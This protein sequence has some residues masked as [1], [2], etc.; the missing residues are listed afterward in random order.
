MGEDEGDTGRQMTER[1]EH[2]EVEREF[3]QSGEDTPA[4]D[5]PKD[6]ESSS[7]PSE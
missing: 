5:T 4:E 1:T 2:T 3:T 6:G 7:P